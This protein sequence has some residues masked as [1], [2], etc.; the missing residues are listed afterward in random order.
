MLTLSINWTNAFIITFLGIGFVFIILCLLILLLRIFGMVSNRL[1]EDKKV[2]IKEKEPEQY[3]EAVAG[4]ESAAIAM[5]MHL[6]F[7]DVHDEESDIITIKNI[8]YRYSPWN[9][10]TY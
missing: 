6:Y 5:A 4:P 3:P 1:S 9:I 2:E 7:A 8:N 10:K